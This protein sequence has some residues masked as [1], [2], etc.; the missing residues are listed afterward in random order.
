[1]YTGSLGA[2]TVITFIPFFTM[3]L[4]KSVAFDSHPSAD[5]EYQLCN[6]KIT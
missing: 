4:L 6:G 2:A 1:M 5:V 3:F